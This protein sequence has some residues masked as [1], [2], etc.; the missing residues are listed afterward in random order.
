MSGRDFHQYLELQCITERAD[1][2]KDRKRLPGTEGS[3]G[4]KVCGA[5]EADRE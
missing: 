2:I 4:G 3:T 1:V 5:C